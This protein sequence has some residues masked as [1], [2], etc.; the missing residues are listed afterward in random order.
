M[1]K[2]MV[3]GLRQSL[4]FTWIIL[5]HYTAEIQCSALF[6]RGHFKVMPSRR[7]TAQEQTEYRTKLI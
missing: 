1:T 5:E 2:V 3:T 6:N 7:H 4:L